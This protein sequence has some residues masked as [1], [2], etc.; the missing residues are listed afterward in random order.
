M[1]EIDMDLK[2]IMLE[3]LSDVNQICKKFDIHYTLIH[4]SALGAVRHGGFIPWDD[5]LDIAMSREEYKRFC[6]IVDDNLPTHLEF[7][8]YK[9]E[10]RFSQTFGKIINKNTTYITESNM[11]WKSY[12]GVFIDIFPFDIVPNHKFIEKKL[13]FYQCLYLL[14]SRGYGANS[15]KQAKKRN[16]CINTV[17]NVILMAIPKSKFNIIRNQLEKKVTMYSKC[18]GYFVD[19]SQFDMLKKKYSKNLFENAELIQFENITVP[20]MK[21]WDN[22]LRITYGDYM[23]LPKLEDRVGSHPPLVLN[24]HKPYKSEDIEQ[25]RGVV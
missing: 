3:M 14:F 18:D 21:D 10:A 9:K 25:F 1:T 20:I 13:Y 15:N 23:K 24:L 11:I 2:R 7:L 6:S 8:N 16:L 5:D 4:G 19:T 12:H 17:S 22:F